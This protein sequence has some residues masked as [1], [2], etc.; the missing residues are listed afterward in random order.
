[1]KSLGRDVLE[2]VASGVAETLHQIPDCPGG[3]YGEDGDG[4]VDNYAVIDED[5]G[6]DTGAR[7][8]GGRVRG[9]HG[10]G[11]LKL[12]AMALE[13]RF[14]RDNPV[15]EDDERNHAQAADPPR[16]PPEDAHCRSRSRS[17]GSSAGAGRYYGGGGLVGWPAATSTTRR[18]RTR[19]TARVDTTPGL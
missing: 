10:L 18:T 4:E 17:W 19:T 9:R 14:L 16:T 15:R 1:M 6:P 2:G 3:A 12:V 8:R 13:R 7:G 5:V 11:V